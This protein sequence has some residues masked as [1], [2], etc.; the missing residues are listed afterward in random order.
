MNYNVKL[1]IVNMDEMLA[2]AECY[3]EEHNGK[4]ISVEELLQNVKPKFKT[5]RLNND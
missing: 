5:E 2:H 1:T 3:R 4:T